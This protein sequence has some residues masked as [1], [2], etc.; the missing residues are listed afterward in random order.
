MVILL[1]AAAF[2]E[3]RCEFADWRGTPDR[4]AGHLPVMRLGTGEDGYIIMTRPR[5]GGKG[6]QL[7]PK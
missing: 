6:Y 1:E 4:L 7:I 3:A 2:D 5:A